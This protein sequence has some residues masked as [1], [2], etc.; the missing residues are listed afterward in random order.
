MAGELR[1]NFLLNYILGLKEQD[2]ARF[3]T[4]TLLSDKFLPSY[5]H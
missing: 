3:V 2:G 5:V 1:G 4:N